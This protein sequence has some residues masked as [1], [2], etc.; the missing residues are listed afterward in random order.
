MLLSPLKMAYI[1]IRLN[2]EYIK[3]L[4]FIFS[5]GLISVLF[6]KVYNVRFRYFNESGE[7]N[8]KGYKRRM[9]K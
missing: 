3:F 2:S 1:F 4:F 5:S 9:V 7:I 6:H 8:I